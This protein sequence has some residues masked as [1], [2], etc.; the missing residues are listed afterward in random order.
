VTRNWDDLGRVTTPL[1]HEIDRLTAELMG[2]RDVASRYAFQCGVLTAERDALRAAVARVEAL[3]QQCAEQTCALEDGDIPWPNILAPLINVYSATM[4]AIDA[5]L[6]GAPA[7]QREAAKTPPYTDEEKQ[8]ARE[9]WARKYEKPW[10]EVSY[11]THLKWY[12]IARQEA[13]EQREADDG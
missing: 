12:W 4:R 5:T 2:L 7:E 11:S 8:L 9:L 13:A 1:A 3:A 10:P 6:A